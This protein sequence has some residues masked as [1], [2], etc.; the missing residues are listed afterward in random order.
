MTAGQ[1]VGR[2]LRIRPILLAAGLPPIDFDVFSSDDL[3]RPF[4]KYC[5]G[6]AVSMLYSETIESDLV[7]HLLI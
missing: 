4:L 3:F 1:V 7:L 2:P 6:Q 5:V